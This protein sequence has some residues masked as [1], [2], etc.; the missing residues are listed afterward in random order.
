[1]EYSANKH[2]NR[3]ISWLYFNERVLQEAMDENTP[4]IERLK[5]LGIF[6][7]NRDEFFRVRVATMN[8]L[9]NFQK[10]NFKKNFRPKKILNQIDEIVAQ[11]EITFT[12]TFNDIIEELKKENIFF[13]NETQLS[14]KQG[15]FVK[16][17]FRE[18]VRP[19][20]FPLMLNEIKNLSNLKDYSFYLAV[21]LLKTTEETKENFALIE[22]PVETLSR[23]L[24]LPEENKSI[25]FIML[26]DVIRFCLNDIF[27]AFGYDKFEAYTIKFTRDAEL[28]IDNDISKSFLELMSDSIKQRKMGVPVRFIYDASIPEF[29]LTKLTKKFKITSNDQLRGGGRYHNFKDLMAF[30]KIGPKKLRFPP[31]PP[32]IHK[33]LPQNKSI[34]SVLKEKDIML[35]YP[36]QSF[37]YIIDFL[38]EASIDPKVKSIKMT[39]YRAA[40]DS[41]VIN[42]LINAARNGKSVTV[43]LELQAR[44]DEQANI[45][46]SGKLQ[47][48]GVK[49]IQTIPGFKVHSKLLLINRKEDGNFFYYSNIGTG[50]FN[51]STAKVYA[52]DSLLTSNQ[53]IS[54]E[55][56]KVFRLF[57]Y[58][59]DPPTFKYLIV[60]PFGLR[61]FFMRKISNEIKN[62]KAG[63]NAWLIFKV[64]SLVD[65]RIVKK[66]YEASQAGV[67]IQLITRGISVLI[68]GIPKLSENIEAISIVDKFLEHSRVF[69]FCNDDDNKYIISSADLMLRN[70]D[71]RI[72]VACPIY[73]KEIQKELRKMLDIQLSDNCKARIISK[74]KPNKYKKTDSSEKIRSQIEIYNYFKNSLL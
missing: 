60:A 51:E 53:N 44:F 15:K 25:Y 54:K 56:D 18:N 34:F 72:E 26:D 58:K 48:E 55:V 43:F 65:K 74:D 62:A 41:N 8:R 28:D 63:K 17:Y 3:E 35:H 38:R 50:N 22:V 57:E 23:F 10:K 40:K 39:L 9:L 1:M 16:E 14:K 29:L 45:Y 19:H 5:F 47:E 42:A 64:N 73:D 31:S 36:Y 24:I 52:D 33:D 6:S 70:L 71:H 67:K 61:N 68:P 49:I 13:I 4:L 59:Y 21:H 46:W 30:P 7:N 11:Q 20:L 27:A 66:L 32:L 2:I 69:V 12:D 37:Q